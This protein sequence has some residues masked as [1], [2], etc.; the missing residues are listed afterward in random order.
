MTFG[1]A[2]N[3]RR[4]VQVYVFTGADV[5]G[6]PFDTVTASNEGGRPRTAST[7]RA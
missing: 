4:T 5:N 6:T 1:G 7:R 2:T 3:Y